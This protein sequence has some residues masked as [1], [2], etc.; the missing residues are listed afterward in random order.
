MGFWDLLY[1]RRCVGCGREGQYFCD[2]CLA[3]TSLETGWRCPEC[4]RA[5]VGGVTHFGCRKK[6]GLDD[7][8]T[9]ASYRG[10]VRLGIHELKYRFLTDMEKEMRGLAALRLKEGLKS[11]QGLELRNLVKTKPAVVPV[12]LYW[13]RKNWRGFNHAEF[14]AKIVADELNLP[15]KTDFLVRSKPTKPQVEM[16]RKERIKN[17]KRV[18]G[19]EAEKLPEKALLVDDVWTTG[20]TMRA[21]GAALKRAGVKVVWGLALSR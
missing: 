10:L 17:V 12:P 8:V 1:P 19:V 13:R 6:H 9:L 15:L 20:A 21:A 11:R 5:S 3:E 18:F 2:R 16:A 14:I 7:L 4:N